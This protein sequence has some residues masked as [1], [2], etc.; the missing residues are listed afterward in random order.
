MAIRQCT[1]TSMYVREYAWMPTTVPTRSGSF[2]IRGME[3]DSVGK[4]SDCG[5]IQVRRTWRL[6]RNVFIHHAI[7]DRGRCQGA[8]QPQFA[9]VHASP[10]LELAQRQKR[11]GASYCGDGANA[12]VRYAA[13][14]PG[15]NHLPWLA[16][17]PSAQIQIQIQMPT[18]PRA[19][20]QT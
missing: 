8:Q 5:A 3:P 7:N 10:G 17:A 13:L 4:R 15:L 11:T 2:S 19:Q 20:Q 6:A 14:W 18:R 1:S 16:L 9:L 12:K